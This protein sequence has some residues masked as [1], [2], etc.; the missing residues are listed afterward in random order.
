MRGRHVWDLVGKTLVGI[1]S[2]RGGQ[3]LV[4]CLAVRLSPPSVGCIPLW[5]NYMY[6]LNRK[7][8]R[9]PLFNS[10][11]QFQWKKLPIWCHSFSFSSAWVVSLTQGST[12]SLNWLCPSHS[13]STSL[14]CSQRASVNRVRRLWKSWFNVLLTTQGK[15]VETLA[16]SSNLA[17][18]LL[19]QH[20][21]FFE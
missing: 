2:D 11:A 3:P 4:L 12:V 18:C 10:L 17:S 21:I 13:H 19:P 8:G 1:F 20:L 16:L 5:P 6:N 7:S 15:T 9:L 14:L